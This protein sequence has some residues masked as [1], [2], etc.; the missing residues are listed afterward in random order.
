MARIAAFAAVED[1][2]E[3]QRAFV[4]RC[5]AG[6]E[7]ARAAERQVRDLLAGLQAQPRRWPELAWAAAS[8]AGG[9][10]DHPAWRRWRDEGTALVDAA[11]QRLDRAGGGLPDL[12][13]ENRRRLEASLARVEAVRL[14]DD[15]ARFARD[16]RALLDR[17]ERE[18]VPVSLLE[19]YLDLAAR[20]EVLAQASALA[21][22]DRGAV[23]AWRARHGQE[24]ARVDDIRLLPE[25]AATLVTRLAEHASLDDAAGVDPT[26]PG[27]DGWRRDAE[28]HLR[29]VRALLAPDGPHATYLAAMPG[30]K[31]A[32]EAAA[33]EMDEA[34]RSLDRAAL[35]WQVNGIASRA[36]AAAVLPL[37]MPEWPGTL[38]A[39]QHAADS[40]NP[41][42]P[43][44]RHLARW[45]AEDGRWRRNRGHVAALLD[46]LTVLERE[47]PRHAGDAAAA[48]AAD[49]LAWR[50]EAEALGGEL[51]FVDALPDTERTAHLAARGMTLGDFTSLAGSVPLMRATDDALVRL[52]DWSRR[53][54]AV[55]RDGAQGPVIA[56]DDAD[57]VSTLI[58]E[59]RALVQA[60]AAASLPEADMEGAADAVGTVVGRLE[61]AWLAHACA[62]V[63]RPWPVRQCGDEGE[64]RASPRRGGLPKTAGDPGGSRRARGRAGRDHRPDGRVARSRSALERRTEGDGGCRRQGPGPGGR[65]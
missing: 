54:A 48:D 15:A 64:G 39:I 35:L 51:A 19:G 26:D 52:G 31:D 41:G 11:H 38:G 16:W 33:R 30:A 58:E 1:L 53:A 7:R 2:P 13:S 37:D 50:R 43:A 61:A 3:D 49:R 44:V 63:C 34:L 46:R 29:H 32:A 62:V 56:P 57:D 28:R 42:E 65:R 40:A 25:R 17:S 45:V 20:G 6:H 24:T 8:R 55:L 10:D 14:K 23:E 5:L 60:W 21:L 59:G 9:V 47:R 36:Q 27:A 12:T 22:D 4:D 18:A